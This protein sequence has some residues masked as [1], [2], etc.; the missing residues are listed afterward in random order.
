MSKCEDEIDIL[1]DEVEY[2]IWVFRW[3]WLVNLVGLI[4][5]IVFR[6]YS[7]IAVAG[8]SALVS[9]IGI[10]RTRRGR[11]LLGIVRRVCAP[12]GQQPRGQEPN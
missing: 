2:S 8:V 11:R 10:G 5:G 3:L 6:Q 9:L 12:C 7:L 4:W 1:K